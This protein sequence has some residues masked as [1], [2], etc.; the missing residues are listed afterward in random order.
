MNNFQ[1]NHVYFSADKVHTLRSPRGIT[2][3]RTKSEP[4]IHYS[5]PLSSPKSLK[6]VVIECRGFRS[7]AVIELAENAMNG[8]I[9]VRT[10]TE[11]SV[12]IFCSIDDLGTLMG[13]SVS[14][15]NMRYLSIYESKFFFIC[16]FV[17][18]CF[19]INQTKSNNNFL[20]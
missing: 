14:M 10:F 2:R 1:W 12:S 4:N 9:P 7:N 6:A 8:Q 17:V 18:I 5:E 20:L 13:L 15:E 11:S 16:Y 3:R 19:S